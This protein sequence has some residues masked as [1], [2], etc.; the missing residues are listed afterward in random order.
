MTTA[1]LA[2]LILARDLQFEEIQVD[3]VISMCHV[4][5][6][7]DV[8]PDRDAWLVRLLGDERY[9]VRDLAGA[10]L[11][12]RGRAA[13]VALAWGCRE[14]NTWISG[15]ARRL[16]DAMFACPA[17]EASRRCDACRWWPPGFECPAGC[18]VD[19]GPCFACDGTGD[20]RFKYSLNWMI[21]PRDVFA[22]LRYEP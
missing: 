7:Q 12:R 15:P 17:C 22:R 1:M 6:F 18:G 2:A 20:L 21:V 13:S 3:T 11:A 10:E 8:L 19:P 5:S 9:V 16:R 14:K 4:D